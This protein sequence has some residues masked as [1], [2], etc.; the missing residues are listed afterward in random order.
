MKGAINC[1]WSKLLF[2]EFANRCRSAAGSVGFIGVNVH[3]SIAAFADSNLYI[4]K[5][6][7]SVRRSDFNHDNFAVCNVCFFCFSSADVQMTFC[8]DDAF[9]QL[10]LTS[11]ANQ[12][13]WSAAS[14]I[15]GQSNRSVQTQAS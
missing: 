14:Q 1:N 12:F 6:E 15:A 3:G 2:D 13:A 5:D 10:Y 11:R 7:A 4:I 9:A 8:N